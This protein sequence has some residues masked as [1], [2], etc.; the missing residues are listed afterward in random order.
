MGSPGSF[1]VHIESF[2]LHLAAERGL[3]ANYRLSVRRSLERF[4]SW[5]AERGLEPAQVA[6][7]LL[8]EYHRSLHAAGLAASS[9]R[10]A[11]VHLRIFFRHLAAK[12]VLPHN[13]AALL[14]TG[15]AGRNLPETLGAEHVA[16]LLESIDPADLPFG[17]RDRAILE[18]LYGS[19]LR[20]SELVNL[21]PEQVDWQEM[22]LRITGKG[23][24]TRYV[25]LGGMAAESLRSYLQQGRPKL[26]RPGRA[27]AALFLSNRGTQLTRER[28]RQIIKARAAAAGI[29]E[30]VYPHI[31]RH[32]FASHLLENG[33]DLRVIQDM[34]GHADLATT[35]VYT[36]VE[37]KRLV[38][39]HR[40]FHPR[41]RKE[42]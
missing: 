26:L 40:A 19:G 2:L 8:A 17:A 13:P 41:G 9:C 7:P 37:Q 31:M 38:S 35:Q 32:S 30:N 33:A 6:E 28:I 27:A 42:K 20:V 21:R 10:V 16:R 12:G 23:N 18:M 29:P 22:F 36:H 24:K 25:P 14:E 15:R 1:A 34:L 5:C 39:L 3:S 11:M 4:D